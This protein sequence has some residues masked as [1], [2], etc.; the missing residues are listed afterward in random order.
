VKSTWRDGV[1]GGHTT[2][3]EEGKGLYKLTDDTARAI[4]KLY[5]PFTM[6]RD[7]ACYCIVN[8]HFEMDYQNNGFLVWLVY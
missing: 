2:G 3:M 5:S 6:R 4:Q 1:A 8:K 7:A